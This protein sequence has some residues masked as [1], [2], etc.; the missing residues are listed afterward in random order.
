M[1]KIQDAVADETG[2][3]VVEISFVSEHSHEGEGE[4]DENF[5][6]ESAVGCA[7]GGEEDVIRSHDYEDGRV[8]GAIATEAG[9]ASEDQYS[10]C[11]ENTDHVAHA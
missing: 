3:Y 7:D 1:E 4:C 2:R 6:E 10:G 5:D 11:Q 8:K 9:G